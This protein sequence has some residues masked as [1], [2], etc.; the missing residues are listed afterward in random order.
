MKRKHVPGLDK[1]LYKFLIIY[2]QVHRQI[3]FF[4]HYA[5]PNILESLDIALPNQVDTGLESIYWRVPYWF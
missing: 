3:I 1:L 4:L 5:D 2:M